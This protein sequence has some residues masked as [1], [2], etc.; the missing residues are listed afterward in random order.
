MRSKA[1]FTLI[2]L[3]VVIAIIALL[4]GILLPA[5]AS[6]RRSAQ[7]AADLS[8][9]RQM[10]L[11][12]TGYSTDFRDWY[13]VL[14]AVPRATLEAEPDRSDRLGL[15]IDSQ[16][17]MGGVA[18]LFSHV[19]IGTEDLRGVGID[20]WA[21]FGPR[22]G[23]DLGDNPT[24]LLENYLDNYG[25]LVSPADKEDLFYL[26]ST[27]AFVN[28]GQI[29]S[30]AQGRPVRPTA[31]AGPEEVA[32]YNISYMYI[33]GLKAIEPAVVS[34]VPL[35][36]GE[37]SGPDVATDAWYGGGSETMSPLAESAGTTPGRYAPIDDFGA[38]GANWVF[39]DGHGEFVDSE[40]S[41]EGEPAS[42]QELFFS[43][44]FRGNSQ[45]INT[46]REDRSRFVRTID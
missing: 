12:M 30:I 37:T 18:G 31:P 5:L 44:R 35:W 34:P 36:G 7:R 45:S 11:A 39:S 40:Q 41:F 1:G 29:T 17:R 20:G 10:G 2:E 28:P 4:I 24:P 32:M 22:R 25:V 26:T 15:L 42:I 8:N 23:Q 3:L 46:I 6:A 16:H 43:S 21:R 33:A 19:Q 13:P 27:M 9:V 14:F 38:D